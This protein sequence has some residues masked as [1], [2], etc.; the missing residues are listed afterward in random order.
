MINTENIFTE[1]LMKYSILFFTLI[2][3]S[4]LF[5]SCSDLKNDIP[6]TTDINI[7]GSEV[8]DTTASNFH[9]KQV[10]DSQ[11]SFQD[12]KQCHD[13]NYSGGITKVSCYSSDCHVSPAINVHEV[14]ITDVQSPNFHGK[15]IADKVRMVSCAQCH[16]NSYQGGV[17]SPSCAN[18]HSGIP[19]HVGDYVNP[20]S[21]NFHGK[22]IADKVSGS[23]VSCAQCHGDSYQGGI[24]SPACANCHAGIPVHVGDYVNPTSPNFHGKF[25]AD[26]FSG[27]MNS[28]A[29]CHGDSFQ[30][31][32]ASPTCANCHSTIPVHVDGIVNPSSPNFHGKYIAANLAWDMRACGSCH[33]ADYSGGIAAPTCLTCH[34][35]TNGPEACNT[36]HGDFNDPS[37][38]APPSALNG[39]IVTT[40]AGVGAHNAHLY[41]N[42]LGNNVRCSTCHKF[43]SSMYAEGHLGSDSKAEVIFGRLA[44]QS[45]A[46]PNYSFSNNTC[47]DTYCHGNFVFYRDS[48]TFAFAYTAATMEG[49]YFSPKWNQVDGSQAAC[50]TCH[51]LPPTGHVA[52]TLNTCVNCHAGVVD[53]QGNIIDQTKHINGVKNV[54]GN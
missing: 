37:K 32:V 35:S 17:V 10:L 3:S 44:V 18:C 20:S 11:N 24:A 30:G 40:Y 23:M 6:I 27:S 49:N 31:G 38:I 34:T 8:F 12:C 4:V 15:F 5:I 9:G 33:S 7:H 42:D 22:F 16:G 25:I 50:G 52:A 36:C 46:N 2:L 26:N 54:F 21:P 28:C 41:E 51:G 14:G 29:Q 1:K 53:N 45:G 47:A 43:P 39:S 19:V 13:A 48:S